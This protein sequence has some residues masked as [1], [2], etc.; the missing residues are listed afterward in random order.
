MAESE[1][2]KDL[3]IEAMFPVTYLYSQDDMKQ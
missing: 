3:S 2:P 1:Q